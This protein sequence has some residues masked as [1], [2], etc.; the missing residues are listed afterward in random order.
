MRPVLVAALLLLVSTVARAE[1]DR[2]AARR[3]F[4]AGSKLYDLG[5]FREAA[6]EYEEAYKAK[7]DPALLFNIGQAYRGAGE[8]QP[9]ITAYRS[10]LRKL[11]DTPNRAEVEGHITRLQKQ[12][13]DAAAQKRATL[14]PPIV[15]P[16]DNQ[17]IT[18]APAKQPLYKKWWLWTAVGGALVIGGIAVGV[19][20]ALPKDAPAPANSVTV[21]F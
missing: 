10:F 8:A 16:T 3:H 18:R 12:L 11:P 1:D 2:E 21:S 7:S 20:F 17:L 5:K 6:G 19:A 13:D 15:A 9:A 14:A 4:D